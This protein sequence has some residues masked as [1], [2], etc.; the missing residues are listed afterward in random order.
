[1]DDYRYLIHREIMT[2]LNGAAADKAT[3]IRLLAK[4]QIFIDRNAAAWPADRVERL[5]L[6][7]QQGLELRRAGR[8]VPEA[9]KTEIRS[10]LLDG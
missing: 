9:I 10:A 7:I 2:T 4:L 1:M 5:E 3:L 6:A 8:E